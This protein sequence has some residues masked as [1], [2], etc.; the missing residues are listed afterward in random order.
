MTICCTTSCAAQC[1][2]RRLWRAPESV[3]R[4][5]EIFAGLGGSCVRGGNMPP[6]IYAK[7]SDPAM[8]RGGMLRS[9]E[10][11]APHPVAPPRLTGSNDQRTLPIP[12]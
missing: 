8:Q 5:C 12:G 6:A 11:F 10:G 4:P 7:L 1:C 3:K 2:D 9:L